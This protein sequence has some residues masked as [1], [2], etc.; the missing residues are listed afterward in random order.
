MRR[1]GF[2]LWLTGCLVVAEGREVEVGSINHL[3][4]AS[5]PY[6]QQHAHNPVDWYPWGEEAFEK[7]RREH[8]PIFL[9]IG[10]STCHW[11]HVMAHESFENPDIARLINRWFVP[12][13]VDREEMPDLNRPFQRV[14]SLLHRRSGEWPLTIFLTEEGNPSSPLLTC[15]QMGGAS[16]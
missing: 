12:V 1:I 2:A 15:R 11:C 4:D 13:K 9:S 3:V 10:Y 16:D 5:S 7:A 6:L 8:K 14:Y